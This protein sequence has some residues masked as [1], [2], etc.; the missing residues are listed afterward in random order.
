MGNQYRLVTQIDTIL[1]EQLYC[2]KCGTP[3]TEDDELCPTCGYSL[4]EWMLEKG[5]VQTPHYRPTNME[6]ISEAIQALFNPRPLTTPPS[7]TVFLNRTQKSTT[8][9][10]ISA[11]ILLLT[12]LGLSYGGAWLT[13]IGF[14]LAGYAVPVILLIYIVRSDRYEREPIALIAYCFGWGAFSGIMAGIIN[15]FITGPFLGVGGAGLIEEPL[16]IAGVYFI[17]KNTRLKNEFNNHLDGIIYGAAAGAGFAGL[18]NFWYITEL[19]FN[20]SYPPL[21][22]IFIRSFTGVMHIAWS[23]IAGR[24]LGLAKAMKGSINQ[25]DLIPGILVSAILHFVWNTSPTYF[26]LILLFPFTLG[27]LRNMIK[28]AVQDERNWGYPQFAPDE[29]D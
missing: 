21:F 5:I 15:A 2:P 25:S 17:A 14:T 3:I 10:L 8:R 18:E 29:Q 4:E 28:T 19:V 6:M 22:A 16:K 9:Y 1:P 11:I 7:S 23:G 24:S 13:Y 12:G 26:S 20:G 27:S